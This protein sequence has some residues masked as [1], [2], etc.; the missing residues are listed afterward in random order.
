MGY[1]FLILAAFGLLCFT[2]SLLGERCSA[3]REQILESVQRLREAASTNQIL[4]D[5]LEHAESRERTRFHL[6]EEVAAR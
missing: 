6:T 4:R 5:K 1:F 3:L 2:S